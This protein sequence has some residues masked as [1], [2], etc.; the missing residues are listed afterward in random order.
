MPSHSKEQTDPPDS[1]ERIVQIAEAFARIGIESFLCAHG[2]DLTEQRYS[3]LKNSQHTFRLADERWSHSLKNIEAALLR[4]FRPD[5]TFVQSMKA[6]FDIL[7]SANLETRE[8]AFQIILAEKRVF[9]QFKQRKIQPTPACSHFK[10]CD[11]EISRAPSG[12]NR[13]RRFVRLWTK[14]V[15]APQ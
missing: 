1:D 7:H 8:Q 13:V 12:R 5:S 15:F 9:E 11:K 10:Q 14:S 6:Y 2:L 4:G 3:H